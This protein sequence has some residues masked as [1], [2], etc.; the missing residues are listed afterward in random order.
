MY[1][2]SSAIG[3]FPRLDHGPPRQSAYLRYL[4]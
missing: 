2:V 4:N 3:E 1:E